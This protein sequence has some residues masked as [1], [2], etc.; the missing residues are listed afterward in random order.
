MPDPSLDPDVDVV[1]DHDPTRW[2]R[3]PD[4][5]SS[6]DLRDRWALEAARTYDEAFDLGSHPQAE[7]LRDYVGQLMTRFAAWETPAQM[8]FL[9]LREPSDKPIPVGVEFYGPQQLGDLGLGPD[10]DVVSGAMEIAEDRTVVG[11]TS[12]EDVEAAPGWRRLFYSVL[13][14]DER[15]YSF[16]RYVRL[17]DSGVLVV[18]RFGGDSPGVVLEA[19]SDADSLAASISVTPRGGR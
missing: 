18:L 17:F 6:P 16:V 1:V 8:R 5:D 14:V 3:G 11:E 12:V 13:G 19:I 10:D 9:R 4:V 15:V 2:L 7:Q